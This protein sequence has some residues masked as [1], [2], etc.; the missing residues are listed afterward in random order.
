M[1]NLTGSIAQGVYRGVLPT[2][3]R[4]R[5]LLHSWIPCQQIEL[6][7]KGKFLFLQLNKDKFDKKENVVQPPFGSQTILMMIVSGACEY[8]CSGG[9]TSGEF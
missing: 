6:F 8:P 7:N 1:F 2:N 9:A 5:N 3:A 4:R